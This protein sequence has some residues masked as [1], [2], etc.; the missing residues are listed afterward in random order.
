MSIYVDYS[1]YKPR[2]LSVLQ[3]NFLVDFLAGRTEN[4]PICE[5]YM[6]ANMIN[7]SNSK[8]SSDFWHY[9]YFNSF[10]K[11]QKQNISKAFGGTFVSDFGLCIWVVC[12]L[13]PWI[14]GPNIIQ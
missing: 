2:S 8:K 14:Y 1:I 7:M 9:G 3:Q 12:L 11:Y 4:N 6:H 5:T 13:V 10:L